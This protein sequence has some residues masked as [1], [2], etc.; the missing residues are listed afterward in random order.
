MLDGVKVAG[1]FVSTHTLV[2]DSSTRTVQRIRT[3]RPL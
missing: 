2:M 3:I 1:G